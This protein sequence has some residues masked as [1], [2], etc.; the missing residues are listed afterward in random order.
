VDHMERVASGVTAHPNDNTSVRFTQN[1][2]EAQRDALEQARP[3][4]PSPSPVPSL[5]PC[6]F[7]CRSS[8]G[9]VSSPPLVSCR[10]SYSRLFGA[11]EQFYAAISG[12]KALAPRVRPQLMEQNVLDCLKV[13]IDLVRRSGRALRSRIPR[14]AR[15]RTRRRI[16]RWRHPKQRC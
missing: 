11:G 15:R 10:W 3:P 1:Y 6:A 13:I 16:Q 14:W 5:C 12:A 7:P 9:T 8:A 2:D 4:D